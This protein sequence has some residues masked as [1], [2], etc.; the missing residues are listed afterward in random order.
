MDNRENNLLSYI[1]EPWLK[2]DLATLAQ[3]HH[4]SEYYNKRMDGMRLLVNG[5]GVTVEERETYNH[6]IRWYDLL[7]H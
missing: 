1:G 2:Y 6:E 4:V 3:T 7:L 5:Q